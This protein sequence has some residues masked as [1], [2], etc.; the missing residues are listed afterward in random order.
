MSPDPHASHNMSVLT[1]GLVF[2]G[3]VVD[4]KRKLVLR[5]SLTEELDEWRRAI[6]VE[7]QLASAT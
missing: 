3:P 1:E 2:G 4:Q 7:L 5:A 6:E